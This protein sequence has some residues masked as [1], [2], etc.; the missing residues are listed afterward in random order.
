MSIDTEES[1]EELLEKMRQFD[2]QMSLDRERLALERK[3]AEDN[4]VLKEQEIAVKKIAANK[5]PNTTK[6]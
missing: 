4:K 3:V 5:K 2:E 6:S 1:K